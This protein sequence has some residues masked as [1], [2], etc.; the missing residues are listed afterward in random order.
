MDRATHLV[1]SIQALAQLWLETTAGVGALW[2]VWAG[3]SDRIDSFSCVLDSLSLRESR[4]R[5]NCM[6]GLS[7]GRRPARKR[8]SS[9]PTVHLLGE[10]SEALQSRKAESTDRLSRERWMKA[11]TVGSGN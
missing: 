2:P 8:A 5:E 7:G 3:K 11:Q 10:A 6:H 4:V 9:D 1:A